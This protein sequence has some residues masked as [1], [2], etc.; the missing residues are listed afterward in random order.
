M[1]LTR[2]ENFPNP[3]RSV[4]VEPRILGKLIHWLWTKAQPL[5]QSSQLKSWS[6]IIQN[7]HKNAVFYLCIKSFVKM[8]DTVY[9]LMA[10]MQTTK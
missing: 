7:V 3:G 1:H 6:K 4:V 9:V 10:Q 8:H 5:G 2:K